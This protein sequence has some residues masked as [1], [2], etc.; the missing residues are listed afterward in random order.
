MNSSSHS[1]FSTKKIVS[2]LTSKTMTYAGIALVALLSFAAARQGY[3]WFDARRQSEAQEVLMGVIQQLLVA[4]QEEKTDWQ[5]VGKIID[6]AYE[7]TKNTNAAAPLLALRSDVYSVQQESAK[8]LEAMN[9]AVEKSP[10]QSVM[11]PLYAIKR[12]LM[13][14]D[15]D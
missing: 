5:A 8:A 11:T 1:S 7:K 4:E 2:F 13:R 6:T 15:G 10:K 12:A 14:I 3:R 9:Q